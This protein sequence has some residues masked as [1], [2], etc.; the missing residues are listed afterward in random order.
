MVVSLRVW[1]GSA[2]VEDDKE[3]LV[4]RPVVSNV[5]VCLFVLFV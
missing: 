2:E 3:L 5:R 1:L 4:D